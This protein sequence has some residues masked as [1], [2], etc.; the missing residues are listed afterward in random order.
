MSSNKATGSS[1]L[2]VSYRKELTPSKK[3]KS[4]PSPL[5]R[6]SPVDADPEIPTTEEPS[7]CDKISKKGR[8]DAKRKANLL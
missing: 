4:P 1:N 6:L 2:G 8:S 7:D 3:L 5:V